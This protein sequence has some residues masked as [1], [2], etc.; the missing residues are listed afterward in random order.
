MEDKRSLYFHIS[1]IYPVIHSTT[2]IEKLNLALYAGPVMNK[3]T[4]MISLLG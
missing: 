2:V 3:E 4:Y 1:F